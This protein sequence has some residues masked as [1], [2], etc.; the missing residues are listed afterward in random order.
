[1]LEKA[2]IEPMLI[3]LLNIEGRLARSGPSVMLLREEGEDARLEEVLADP[4]ETNFKPTLLDGD[5]LALSDDLTS[6]IILNW[7][8]GVYAT[9]EQPHEED[10]LLTVRVPSACQTADH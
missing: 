8:L 6:T 3:T 9:L 2:A 7:K 10:S 4:L 5:I 1:M